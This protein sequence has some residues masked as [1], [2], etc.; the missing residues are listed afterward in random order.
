[1]IEVLIKVFILISVLNVSISIDTRLRRGI[2]PSL[3]EEGDLITGELE[4]GVTESFVIK[5]LIHRSKRRQTE[6]SLIEIESSPVLDGYTVDRRL[7]QGGMGAVYLV[8]HSRTGEQ[9]A[10]KVSTGRDDLREEYRITNLAYQTLSAVSMGGGVRI[11][12]GGFH[13]HISS[14]KSTFN[15]HICISIVALYH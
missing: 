5:K 13:T 14:I 8:E 3:F 12:F 4:D 2:T 6:S 7:G 15:L 10:A 9:Y 1:M 11:F